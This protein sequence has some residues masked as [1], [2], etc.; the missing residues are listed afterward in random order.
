MSVAITMTG[1]VKK[2]V[3]RYIEADATSPDNAR[4]PVELGCKKS[5]VVKQLVAKGV[6][7][8]IGDGKYY[9]NEDSLEGFVSKER[10][11]GFVIISILM[12]LALVLLAYYL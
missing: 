1:T 7:I 12:V 8:H 11:I 9:L 6:L 2:Y 3:N 4:T 10:K 5:S